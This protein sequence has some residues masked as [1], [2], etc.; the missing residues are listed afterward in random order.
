MRLFIIGR[1]KGMKYKYN[2]G[3]EVALYSIC[4]GEMGIK[5]EVFS[6]YTS[7]EENHPAGPSSS[8]I[9]FPACKSAWKLLHIIRLPNHVFMAV[10]RTC[11]GSLQR[12]LTTSKSVSGTP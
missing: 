7:D 4:G 6:R 8:S 3:D 10:I 9:R 11:E 12:F 2:C 1:R 5:V